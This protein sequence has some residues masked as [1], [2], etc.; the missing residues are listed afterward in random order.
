KLYV[1]GGHCCV[2]KGTIPPDFV[3]SYDPAT[4]TWTA[5]A[6]VPTERTDPAYGVMGGKIYV[7]GG[8]SADRTLLGTRE[9]Y[10]PATDSWTSLK[11]M[12]SALEGASGAV[13]GGKL[14]VL[15]GSTASSQSS[16]LTIFD[17]VYI[18][19]PATDSWS[20]GPSLT[21]PRYDAAAV[22]NGETILLAGGFLASRP[23]APVDSL[24]ALPGPACAPRNACPPSA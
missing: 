24:P 23:G 5:R 14:Y 12:P 18:Y 9:A 11:R 19:D 20:V 4:D 15:G 1:F 21:S 13:V 22:V 2:D 17:Q 8:V 6:A 7:A 10:D 3:D 16:T